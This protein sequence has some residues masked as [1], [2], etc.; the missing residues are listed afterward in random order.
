MQVILTF[1][2]TAL[3]RI[4][5][6]IATKYGFQTAMNAAFI[7]MWLALIASFT[8]A[9]NSCLSVTGTCGGIAM[10][11]AALPELF[12]FGLSLVPSELITIITCLVSLHASGWCAI[13]LSRIVRVKAGMNTRDLTVL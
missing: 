4:F 3:T 9:A 2:G 12:K 7:T 11:W 1:F 10:N 13:V 8:V 5:S 6:S